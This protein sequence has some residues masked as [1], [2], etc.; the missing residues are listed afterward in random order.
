MSRTPRVAC[1][2]LAFKATSLLHAASADSRTHYYR[3]RTFGTEV[4]KPIVTLLVWELN[5]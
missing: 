1:V 4:I 2:E 5:S 3:L